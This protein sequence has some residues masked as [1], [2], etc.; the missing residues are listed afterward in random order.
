MF[1]AAFVLASFVSASTVEFRLSLPDLVAPSSGCSALAS[2]DGV[3]PRSG[4]HVPFDN[5]AGNGTTGAKFTATDGNG[6]KV[7]LPFVDGV[8][9][10]DGTSKIS[11]TG[12]QY[13]FPP[14]NG[15]FNDDAIRDGIAAVDGNDAPWFIVLGD[16]PGAI[17]GGIGIP[18]NSGLT[19]DLD[20]IEAKYPGASAIGIEGTMGISYGGTSGT[21]SFHVLA[22]GMP[23]VEQ[24]LTGV[25][26]FHVLAHPIPPQ[27]RFLTIAVADLSGTSM[28]D[29]AAV[30]DARLVLMGGYADCNG[31]GVPDGCD[32][33]LGTSKDCD[34]DALPDDCEWLAVEYGSGFPGGGGFTPQA[35][36][37]GCVLANG[38]LYYDLSNGFGGATAIVLVGGSKIDLAMP[39]GP[40][41]LVDGPPLHA[42]AVKLGG[43]GYGKGVHT[44]FG[45]LQHGL[46]SYSSIFVQTFVIDPHASGGVSATRGIEL[47][48]L[49]VQ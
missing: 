23:I 43:F 49:A 9:T 7:D 11:S 48:T 27:A 4:M 25:D 3:S 34:L 19:F 8:F 39:A 21:L 33:E 35:T 26:A 38:T 36:I 46:L 16:Q 14:T 44:I 2:H 10:L 18:G 42:V 28:F 40:H 47:K 32:F 31:N 20:R 17:R 30:A 12:I 24:T 22:D 15:A 37:S 5:Y 6:P 13:A 41:L 1:L 45:T 29:G